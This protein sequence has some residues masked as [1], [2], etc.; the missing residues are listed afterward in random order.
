MA[1]PI[2]VVLVATQSVLMMDTSK[3]INSPCNASTAT[4]AMKIAGAT[5]HRTYAQAEPVQTTTDT[6]HCSFETGHE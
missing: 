6:V 2:L 4:A 1:Q 3:S 5:T